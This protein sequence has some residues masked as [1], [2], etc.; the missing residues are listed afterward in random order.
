M[1][2]K[3]LKR[4]EWHKM[5]R[6]LS[7][8]VMLLLFSIPQQRI[9]DSRSTEDWDFQHPALGAVRRDQESL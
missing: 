5:E 3:E 6:A 4:K 1:E 9:I 8:H 7:L 2:Q